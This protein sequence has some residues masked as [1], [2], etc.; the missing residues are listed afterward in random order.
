MKLDLYNKSVRMTKGKQQREFIEKRLAEVEDS[1][2]K[3]SIELNEFRKKNNTIDLAEQTR[4]I[5]ASYSEM[6][7]EKI[8]NEI[9]LEFS[10]Q[11]FSESNQKIEN[12][13]VKNEILNNKILE[14][15]KRTGKL[16]PKYLLTIDEIPDIALQN[17]QILLNIFVTR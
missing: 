14:M 1:I 2:D 10:E 12:L 15:E 11:F 5:V 8:K 13:K 7:S 9:E 17:S 16:K 3:L 4:S 6:V